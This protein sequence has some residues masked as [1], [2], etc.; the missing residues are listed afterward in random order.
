MNELSITTSQNVEIKFATASLG[1][2]MLA[3]FLDMVMKLAYIYG[4]LYLTSGLKF[5]KISEMETLDFFVIQF[6]LFSPALFYTFLFETFHNGQTIG[7]QIMKIKVIKIDGY[8]ASTVDF[9][10]RWLF[11]VIEINLIM[12]IG[13][14][15]AIVLNSKNQRL[16][17]MVAGTAVIRLSYKKGA[18]YYDLNT[19]SEVYEPVFQQVIRF[20]DNDV[21]IIREALNKSIQ[22]KDFK[23]Q[24][25]LV[26]KIETTLHLKNPYTSPVEFIQVVLKDYVHLTSKL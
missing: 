18:R 9:L 20:S 6:I 14:I 7:K 24:F 22:N 25:A 19:I 2:R 21:R 3:F 12:G 5:M 23:L 17:D 4:M 8:Q 10:I 1:E 26:E 13:A 15:L 16:G 11:R